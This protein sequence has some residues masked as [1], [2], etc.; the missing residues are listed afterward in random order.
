MEVIFRK[1]GVADLEE[2]A[3][4]SVTTFRAAFEDQNDPK[5]FKVYLEQAF[6]KKQL[7]D[8]LKNPDT[9][10]Y[11]TLINDKLVGYLKI[12][13]QNAQSEFQELEGMELERIYVKMPY[14]GKGIGLKMLFFVESMAKEE[15]KAYLWLGVWEHNS[16]AIRFY[17]RHGFSKFGTHPYFIGKDQQTDWLLKKEFI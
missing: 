6:S 8:E 12:N 7:L 14:Q 10:F 9:S 3:N 13:T 16:K 1:C 5:D 15:H 11:F 17:E 4:I 2:L